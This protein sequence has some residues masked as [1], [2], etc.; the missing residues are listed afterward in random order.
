MWE[1]RECWGDFSS[2][3]TTHNVDISVSAPFLLADNDIADTEIK[4]L[5]AVV[6]PSACHK[7]L[8]NLS[9]CMTLA[10]SEILIIF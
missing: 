6:S 1:M 2:A 5:D 10:V 4:Q 3:K 7:P 9:H 8:L